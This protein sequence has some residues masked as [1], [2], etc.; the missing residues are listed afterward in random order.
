MNSLVLPELLTTF[1]LTV[2]A[3]NQAFPLCL[4]G[5]FISPTLANLL[6]SMIRHVRDESSL[7]SLEMLSEAYMLAAVNLKRARDRQ[8]NK[9]IKAKPIFKVGNLVL[10]RNFKKQIP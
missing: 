10:G 1:S 7:C 3:K 5:M 2:K 8:P 9:V 4:E 6:Q